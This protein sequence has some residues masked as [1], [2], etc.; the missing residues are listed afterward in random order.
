[1]SYSSLRK[2]SCLG[3]TIAL[4]SSFAAPAQAFK[5]IPL[6]R[7]Y[8]PTGSKATQ[9]YE[10]ENTTGEALAVE[11]STAKREMDLQG[12]DK[13]TPA[14]TEFMIYPPQILLQPGE[15]QTVRVTWLGNPN[16]ETE[17]AYRLI[18]EQLPI[19]LLPKATNDKS[20][21]LTASVKLQMRYIG[22]IYI[23][24]AM[25]QPNVIIDKIESKLDGNKPIL[26]ITLENQGSARANLK[27]GNLQVISNL[28]TSTAITLT[29]AQLGF[30]ERPTLLAKHKRQIRV[31][32]PVGLSHGELS[33]RLLLPNQAKY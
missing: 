7:I 27:D 13:L 29:A 31:P 5:L 4:L 20:E 18:A 33:G 22:S 24:P 21:Q 15:S 12:V 25:S 16:P 14:D 19:K 8:S 17:L 11:L 28:N 6:S 23:R 1:M 3:F 9:S 2:I 30:N 26:E 32:Y 10:I